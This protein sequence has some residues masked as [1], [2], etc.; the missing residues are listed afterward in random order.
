MTKR[1]YHYNRTEQIK[2]F[3][4][5]LKHDPCMDCSKK[6]PIECMQ[7]DHVRGT[8]RQT[9]ASMTGSGWPTVLKELAK[10]DLVCSNCH[11]RRTHNRRNNDV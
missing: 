1:E 11:C 2:F 10:C 5:L 4:W 6:Y 8:K 7:F 9:V 3:L